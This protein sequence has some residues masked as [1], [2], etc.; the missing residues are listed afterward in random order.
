MAT[1]THTNRCLKI[2][3]LLDSVDLDDYCRCES[4]SVPMNEPSHEIETK[5][6]E[7]KRNKLPV[8]DGDKCHYQIMKI[9]NGKWLPLIPVIT[10]QVQK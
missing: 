2:Q 3:Y 5:Q 8:D 6:T 7:I 10:K 9:I 1:S 4:E